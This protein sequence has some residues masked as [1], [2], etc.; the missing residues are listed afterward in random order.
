M[1]LLRRK[2]IDSNK[3][4][5]RRYFS[6]LQA[7]KFA[8]SPFGWGEV[9]IR[10]FEAI[11]CRSVLIKPDMGHLETWPDVYRSGETYLSFSWDLSHF[12]EWF[13]DVVLTGSD[14][15]QVAEA[16]FSKYEEY[17]GATGAEKFIAKIDSVLEDLGLR[18]D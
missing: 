17:V 5:R 14:T 4:T 15:G 7:S 16:A 18:R 6:E 3:V 9:C 12:D 11:L 8:V 2:G 1:E 10:D 13:E